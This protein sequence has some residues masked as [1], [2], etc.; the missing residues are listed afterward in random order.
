MEFFC[1][2]HVRSPFVSPKCSYNR[3]Y[4]VLR[5]VWTVRNHKLVNVIL[6]GTR[7]TVQINRENTQIGRY[8]LVHFYVF[9]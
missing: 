3:V 5:I 7:K 9:W 8:T 4:L 2:N 6:T 1:F